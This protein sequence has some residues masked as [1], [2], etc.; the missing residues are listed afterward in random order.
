MSAK[1]RPDHLHAVPASAA[2]EAD[3]TLILT[4]IPPVL[5][6]PGEYAAVFVTVHKH[7]LFAKKRPALEL[8]FELVTDP[9]GNAIPEETRLSMW[10]RLGPNGGIPPSSKW[11]R[12]WELV[13][14]RRLRHGERHTSGILREKMLRVLVRTVTKDTLQ[15]DLAAVSRY[16][17]IDRVLRVETGG[18]PSP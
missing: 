2:D 14:G 17:V 1:P 11:A 15:Q 3:V 13:A 18:V 6:N 16:S 5:V 8:I 10:C 7:A 9:A 12:T 4:G